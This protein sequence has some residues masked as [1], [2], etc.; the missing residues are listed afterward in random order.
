MS[1]VTHLDIAIDGADEIDAQ[2]NCIK[3]GGGCH[4]QEKIVA[5]AAAKFVLIADESKE[6]THLGTVWLKGVPVEV[7]PLAMASVNAKMAALGGRS[8]LRM[9]V[10]KA[11]PVVTDNGNFILDVHFGALDGARWTPASLEQ[12]REATLFYYTHYAYIMGESN[13]WEEDAF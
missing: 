3:G 7:V 6:A 13:L 1:G 9:A 10:A 5:A 11:G 8:K 4:V 12:V 2:L